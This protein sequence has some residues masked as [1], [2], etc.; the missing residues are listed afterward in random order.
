VS[1]RRRGKDH[2][3]VVA[4]RTAVGYASRLGQSGLRDSSHG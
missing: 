1:G 2:V 3:P 4:K